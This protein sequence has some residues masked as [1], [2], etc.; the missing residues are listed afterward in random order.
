MKNH[1]IKSYHLEKEKELKFEQDLVEE[2]YKS[3]HE[4][5]NKEEMK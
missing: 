3:Y 2:L 1:K 4:F 5:H